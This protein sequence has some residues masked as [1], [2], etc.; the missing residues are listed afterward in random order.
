MSGCGHSRRGWPFRSSRPAGL[1][2][3]PI[4]YR[5]FG[6]WSAFVDGWWTYARWMNT[7]TGRSLGGQFGLGVDQFAEYY[8]DRPI[9][10]VVI[11]AFMTEMVVRWRA[12]DGPGRALRAMVAGWWLAAWIEL[13]LS[14]RYSSHYFSILAVPTILMIGVLVGS[15]TKRMRLDQ[16]RASMS[17]EMWVVPLAVAILTIQVGGTFSFREGLREASRF[18]G[19]SDFDARREQLIDGRTH[20]VRA[21]LDLVSEPDDPLLMW[22][23]YPW[24]YLNLHR[25]PATRYIWKNF[26][27]G[28]IYLARSGPQYV[29]P[30]TWE[31]FAADV[32]RTNPTAF[33]VEAVNPVVS[34]TP[35]DDIV[36]EK[37]TTVFTD[38]ALTLAFRD[39]LAAWLLSPPVEPSPAQSIDLEPGTPA[40]LADDACVRL[41]GDIVSS[42]PDG[43]RVAFGFGSASSVD[44]VAPVIS[45][46]GAGGDTA[47]VTSRG[48]RGERVRGAGRRRAG[49][50]DSVHA[51]RRITGSRA[52][53]RRVDRRCRRDARRQRRDHGVLDRRDPCREPQSFVATAREWVRDRDRERF[54]TP[55]D[56]RGE[57]RLPL[58]N[59]P[60]S[61]PGPTSTE[62]P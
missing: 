21:A 60:G 55:P 11:V 61:D 42:S 50:E 43:A 13:A 35:F 31:T 32:E 51:G 26:L 49:R 29:L 17:T 28:Q 25:V 18:Q 1:L 27:L 4:Y 9:L 44:G 38:E 5:I 46:A 15:A 7:A 39:D 10:F 40:V 57:G 36:D 52:R 58:T 30:G 19:I 59:R 8:G 41:D 48:H 62:S 22:T 24:P 12:L 3:A 54:V 2:S 45:L 56:Y 6:P 33:V 16:V 47:V 23:S 53:R 34:G 14:Q 20:M 37:F